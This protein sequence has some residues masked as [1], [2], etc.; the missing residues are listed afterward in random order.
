[1]YTQMQNAAMENA[2]KVMKE[3]VKTS[4]SSLDG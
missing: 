4:T 1:M 3:K 2:D